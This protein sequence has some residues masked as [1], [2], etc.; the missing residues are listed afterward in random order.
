MVLASTN[1]GARTGWPWQVLL[2]LSLPLIYFF[3]NI[4]YN[5][6]FHPLRK[7]PGPLLNRISKIPY[8]LMLV[9]GNP[10]YE[11]KAMH[12]KYGS[13]V[14]TA[15]SEL[16]FSDP[17]AWQDI[18]GHRKSSQ[19]E[20]GKEMRYIQRVFDSSDILFSD[21]ED[22]RRFRRILSHGFSNQALM[23]QQSLIMTYVEKLVS[24]LQDKVSE[25][26]MPVDV[27]AWYNFTTFDIIADLTF[28]EAFGLLDGGDYHPWVAT[29]FASI[30]AGTLMQIPNFYPALAWAIRKMM[31]KSLLEKRE[32]HKRFTADRVDKRLL[33]GVKRP[34]YME[35]I[36]TQ[37]EKETGGMS[38]GEIHANANTLI[39][40][41][42]ET[43]ATV[44]S[45]TTYLCLTNPHV[46]EKVKEEVRS[47]FSSNSE[48]DLHSVVKLD[49]M[50]A[51]FE[52]AMRVYPPVPTN[53]GRR[54]PKGGDTICGQF[55]PEDTT[56]CIWQLALYK[57]EKYFKNPDKF[58]P[59]RWLDDPEY[60]DDV[61]DIFQPF[62]FG[63]RSC[64]GRNL[65]YAEMR[66]I[67]AKILYDFELELMPESAKWIDHKMY[68]LWEKPK[69]MV[70]FTP[71][72]G[73]ECVAT[74]A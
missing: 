3:Y 26:E 61:R 64:L 17:K 74:L 7:F 65:A 49:Y 30:K 62:H 4:I 1:E 35:T 27:T 51:M 41:G 29:I 54:T 72:K 12:D 39:I 59:E 23:G 70:K 34:D 53:S 24:R 14:R 5:L 69:L 9:R 58:A 21:R 19:A 60:K 36:L 50:L 57:D 31:P 11:I 20:N 44:L 45:A 25:G 32:T 46:L 63:P 68:T 67:F 13:I 33:S 47:S 43:T 22:H 28:G 42:S 66:V 37:R 55:V 48:I 15:P 40:A 52:E 8:S 16:A 71:A 2:L 6:F 18:M 38:R 10:S 56:L 73:R